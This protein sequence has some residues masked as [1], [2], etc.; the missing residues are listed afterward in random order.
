[1]YDFFWCN[2]Q[3]YIESN[4]PDK[5]HAPCNRQLAQAY[6]LSVAQ[7]LK[8]QSELVL[9]VGEKYPLRFNSG[10]KAVWRTSDKK[11]AN[12]GI[13]GNIYAKKL[14]KALI[15]TVVEKGTLGIDKKALSFCFMR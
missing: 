13:T 7:N 8:S 1:M 5:E 6:Y 15:P 4:M 14:G 2:R 3:K 11:I 10:A 9:K 12:V